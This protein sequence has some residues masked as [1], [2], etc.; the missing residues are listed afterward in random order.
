MSHHTVALTVVIG[1]MCP[2]CDQGIDH[3]VLCIG[4]LAETVDGY[5]TKERFLSTGRSGQYGTGQ[6]LQAGVVVALSIE[7][8]FLHGST[9]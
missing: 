5:V 6:A 4:L 2:V 7:A 9:G 3:G 1:V 8:P